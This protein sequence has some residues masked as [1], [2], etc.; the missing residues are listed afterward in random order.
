MYFIWSARALEFKLWVLELWLTCWQNNLFYPAHQ[1]Q[2]PIPKLRI[3]IFTI[4]LTNQIKFYKFEIW[5]PCKLDELHKKQEKSNGRL[6]PKLLSIRVFSDIAYFSIF[7]EFMSGSVPERN[8]LASLFNI[9]PPNC[10]TSQ[11]YRL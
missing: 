3:R 7:N 8:N 5:C 11:Y 1:I 2:Q 9:F 6:R 10:L 4:F